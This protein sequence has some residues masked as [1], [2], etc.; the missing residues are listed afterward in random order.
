MHRFYRY[1][2]LAVFLFLGLEALPQSIKGHIYDEDGEPLAFATLYVKEIATG[3][4]ANAEGFYEYR[5]QPG[6]YQVVFRYTGY[7]SVER[8]VVIHQNAIQM[9]INMKPQT[10]MMREVIAQAKAE[11]PAYMIMRKAIAKSKYHLNQLDSYTAEVY[12]KG[13]G[14]ILDVPFFLRKEMAKEGI[15]SSTMFI[16]ESVSMITYERPSTYNERVISVFKSGDDNSTSPNSFIFGSFYEDE[17]AN[18]ISP[19]A[20]NAFSYYRFSYE[21][22]FTDQG[23]LINKIKVTPRV[24]GPN[25]FEG[26][27]YIVEDEWTIHSLALQ[28]TIDL[29]IKFR[30][31]QQYAKV[32]S[33]WMPISQQYKVEGKIFG[34][35]FEYD[36]LAS[37]SDYQIT[38]NPAMEFEVSLVDEKSEKKELKELKEAEELAK[39]LD[40]LSDA[41]NKKMARKQMRKMIREYE[42]EERKQSEEPEVVSVRNMSIDSLA[43]KKDSA[44]WEKVRPIPLSEREVRGYARQDSLSRAEREENTAK[45]SDTT[46]RKGKNIDWGVLIAG[47]TFDF[48][49]KHSVKVPSPVLGLNYN[50]VEGI[51]IDWPVTYRYK[52]N[53]SRSFV[54]KPLARYSTLRDK[55]TGFVSLS[56]HAGGGHTVSLSGGRY[57]F[58]YNEEEPIE[59][60][61]NAFTTLFLTGNFMKIL[62]KD[63]V[64]TNYLFEPNDKLKGSAYVEYGRRYELNNRTDFLIF[65]YPGRSFTPNIPI[66]NELDDT[67]FNPHEFFIAGISLEYQPFLKYR[68]RNGRKSVIENSSPKFGIDYKKGIP[69]FANSEVD[70]DFI[71]AS[72]KQKFKIGVRGMLDVNFVTG[73]FV[74]NTS[75][76]FPDFKHFPG[77]LTPV[78]FDDPAGKYRLLDYYAYSTQEW[79]VSP[80]LHYQFRKLLF[81]QIPELRFMGLKENLLTNI[82]VTPG[83]PVY[84]EF[85]Y[86]IDNIFRLLRLEFITSFEDTRY[87]RFG[88]R[89]GISTTLSNLVEIN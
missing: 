23:T 86:T 20:R 80:H 24:K 77:N 48:A 28:T 72:Y 82:L 41:G 4:T 39:S 11:D 66:N 69:G 17:V 67:G 16:S 54:A 60:L 73:G 10:L 87:L 55:A 22:A 70:Y 64:K 12:I 89:L 53:D 50:T 43:Y 57:I 52:I 45:K 83:S 46:K 36:Y 62:E 18:S 21:A 59:P 31:D 74:N 85:G 71:Q 88:M 42:K 78:Q 40:D 13:K 56:Y 14:R 51:N 75:M 1:C 68:I 33:A 79:F 35:S 19:L 63:F 5:L 27:I 7:E 32:T 8:T 15:D 9:D 37:M 44:Y 76:Y 2:L 3:T 26:H 47:K 38:V 61:F 25:V 58:Q 49:K 81:T 34:F 84:Y 65:Q 29:G 6:T 30:I